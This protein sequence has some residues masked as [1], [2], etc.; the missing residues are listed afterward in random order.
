MI[1]Q[2]KILKYVKFSAKILK[3]IKFDCFSTFVCRVLD[4]FFG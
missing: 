3:Y 2:Y 1:I 4:Q